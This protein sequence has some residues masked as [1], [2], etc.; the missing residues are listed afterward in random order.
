MKI[1]I[2]SLL[3][4]DQAKALDF[5]TDKLGFKVKTDEP[6]GEFRW[7]TVVGP[8][9]AEGVELSLE[10]S[11]HKAVPPFKQQLK[12]D[13]IPMTSF[14]VEDIDGEYKRL[15]SLDVVF[16]QEPTEAGPY[17]TAVFDDTCGNLIQLIQFS[18]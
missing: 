1:W 10:P 2:T 7:I 17:T 5:Y 18:E 6:M 12:E 14:K 8:N 4:D 9:D 13:G 16:A 3:V 15:K 11:V